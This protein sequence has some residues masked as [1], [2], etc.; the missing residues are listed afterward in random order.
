MHLEKR[1]GGLIAAVEAMRRRETNLAEEIEAVN[2]LAVLCERF[3]ALR[4][5]AR[6]IMR[7][8]PEGGVDGGELQEAALRHGLLEPSEPTQEERDECG[9]EEGDAW[10]RKTELLGPNAS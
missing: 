2:T 3:V 6:D 4:A 8:W 7:A 5:F 1:P 9:L 10:Y